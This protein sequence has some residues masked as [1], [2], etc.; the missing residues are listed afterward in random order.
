MTTTQ[1]DDVTVASGRKRRGVVIR[2][3]RTA[4]ASVGLA[5]IVI[6]TSILTGT[7]FAP[8]TAQ[9]S[10]ALRWAAGVTST[11]DQGQWWTPF[12]SLFVPNDLFQLVVCVVF[13]LT[14]FAL[15]ERL[16]GTARAV[17]AFVATGL[18]GAILGVFIQWGALA[19]GELW[20]TNS[21]V[22]LVLD[23]TVGI[24]G[25]LI[26]A[27]AFARALWR[28]RIRVVTF[29]FVIMF[30]LYNGDSDNFYRLLAAVL[31]LW[32]GSFMSRTP[33]HR[34]WHHSSHAETRNLVAMIVAVSGFGPLTALFSD[35]GTGPLS[36]ISDLLQLTHARVIVQACA[37]HYSPSC[38]RELTLVSARGLGPILLS[39]VPL[40]LLI[41]AAVGLRVG[42]RYA[43]VLAIVV[44]AGLFLLSVLT[45]IF[46]NVTLEADTPR[47][48]VQQ[49]ETLLWVLAGALIPIAVM[50]L[51]IIN[52]HQFLNLAP[53]AAVRE[54]WTT[55]IV[56]FVVL[57]AAYLVAGAIT[58]SGYVPHA[59]FGELLIDSV[60][61]FTPTGFDSGFGAVI[62]PQASVTLFIYRWVGPIFWIVFILA[63]LR[64]YRTTSVARRT[65]TE[66][67]RFRELLKQHGGGTLGFMGTWPGNVYWFSDDAEAAVA[68]R[69]INRIA[70]ALSD[71]VCAPA[72]AAQTIREFVAYCDARSWTPVFYSFHEEHLPTFTELGWDSMSVGEETLM[73]PITLDMAGKPWQK[74]RQ[75]LNRGIKENMTTLWTT[76]HDL[77]LPLAAQINAISEQWVSE[78]EL[79]EMG[80]TLGGMEEL[81]DPDVRL[82][83]AIGPD[84]RMQA[85]TSWLP[86]YRDGEVVGW[87][88]D[89]MRRGDETIPLIMEY[90]IA[91]AALHMQKEGVEV[92][93][94]SGAP[95]A[96]KPSTPGGPPAEETAMT[97][98]L[99]FL[100]KTLE[101]A[102]G[103]SSLFK[104]KSKFNPTY[105]T[106]YMA[107]PDPVALAAIG[108]AIGKAYLPDASAAEYLALAKT[109]MSPR[110]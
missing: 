68:Y 18:V 108:S 28:R 17:I 45:V 60:R 31:G 3:L 34:P 92:L 88:I 99:E 14:L 50:V 62:V 95:L 11:I 81:K 56:A 87:T 93:S 41:T 13:S 64:R 106:M 77:P 94:L 4:P 12:T 22:D 10:D 66:G 15:A 51:V 86:S 9:G 96:T 6:I 53:T 25:A 2:Y 29:A 75:G 19:I 73:H 76:W 35:N 69:V 1:Q 33:L 23:P 84:G 90:V 91:S 80:F 85:I 32:M 79:P 65:S 100:A 78:K 74:V 21:S 72:R 57:V 82:F 48:Y 44:N 97:R 20:A 98:L 39:L 70:I 43:Y 16:L 7:M 54:Y 107:Y 59:S 42:R 46:G 103:F 71:P 67:R 63:T 26:T 105:A 49:Y 5:I 8:S 47:E 101:P 110:K 38:D 36:F 58:L 89:F 55:I 102:Y 30:V 61:R 40:A 24:I 104:F 27:S 37:I 109:L 83:L 52:R